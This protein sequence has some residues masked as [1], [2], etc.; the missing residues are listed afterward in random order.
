MISKIKE[1]SRSDSRLTSF[2]AEIIISLSV[3][4]YKIEIFE[5][6]GESLLNACTFH[7]DIILK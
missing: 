5:L 6:L 3:K 1:V 2:L 4:P 7:S